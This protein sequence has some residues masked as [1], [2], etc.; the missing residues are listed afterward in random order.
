MANTSPASIMLAGLVLAMCPPLFE[1]SPIIWQAIPTLGCC[2]FIAV[3][4]QGII[5][6]GPADKKWL[7]SIA[8]IMAVLAVITLLLAVK[9]GQ[10]IAGLGTGYLRLFAQSAKM[11]ILAAVAM[12]VFFLTAHLGARLI[13]LRK[14]ALFSVMV[15]DIF[16]SARFIADHVP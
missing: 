7:L 6:A 2:I 11:Y 4:C 12:T 10:L 3:G 9:Y 5:S 15:F 13:L 14:A 8:A 1:I 16:F